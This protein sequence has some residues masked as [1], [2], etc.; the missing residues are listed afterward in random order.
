VGVPVD[1][2]RGQADPF[3]HPSDAVSAR[4]STQA[5]FENMQ[6]LGDGLSHR[7]A[8][9]QARERILKDDL[10]VAPQWAQCGRLARQ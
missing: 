9:I 6:R 8:W 7:H 2:V 1:H 4:V 3:Q 5:G 10:Q